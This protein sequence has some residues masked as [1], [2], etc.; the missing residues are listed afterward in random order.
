MNILY[1]IKRPFH[2]LRKEIQKRRPLEPGLSHYLAGQRIAQA[3]QQ[4]SPFFAGRLGYT[5]SRCLDKMGAMG[6][7][8]TA[9]PQQLW[10]GP[11]VFPPTERQFREFADAY[12]GALGRV[13]LLGLLGTMDERRL[14]SRYGS[15]PLTCALENLEPYL[16]PEPWSQ[17]LAGL[18]VLVVS[19]LVSACGVRATQA[20]GAV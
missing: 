7:I 1:Q 12:L 18:R 15:N 19:G 2:R 14:L 13:D 9:I 4:K 10:E 17:H 6:M 16:G 8:P 20:M 11:G 3:I 5:E